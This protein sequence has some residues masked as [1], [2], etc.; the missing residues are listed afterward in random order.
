MERFSTEVQIL[1]VERTSENN[2][3]NGIMTNG[4]QNTNTTVKLDWV[5]KPC[6]LLEQKY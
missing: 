5:L 2:L 6:K 3:K 4:F 1:Q